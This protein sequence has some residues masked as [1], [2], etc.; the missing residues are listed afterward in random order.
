MT[1]HCKNIYAKINIKKT[2][3]P[4]YLLAKMLLKNN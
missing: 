4:N 3:M 1:K 2:E